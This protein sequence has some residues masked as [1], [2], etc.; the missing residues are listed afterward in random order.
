[1]IKF[2]AHSMYVYGMSAWLAAKDLLLRNA[3]TIHFGASQIL[4]EGHPMNNAPSTMDTT[5]GMSNHG[6]ETS[7]S[8]FEFNSTY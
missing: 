8:D 6:T 1:M 7:S 5:Q 2:L 4:S 3:A